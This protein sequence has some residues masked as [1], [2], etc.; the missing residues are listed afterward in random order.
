MKKLGRGML[1]YLAASLIMLPDRFADVYFLRAYFRQQIQAA[2]C[3]A[4][5]SGKVK[6]GEWKKLQDVDESYNIIGG[7]KTYGKV[8]L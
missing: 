6:T 1:Q 4:M 2:D 8:G 7:R 3:R 5:E